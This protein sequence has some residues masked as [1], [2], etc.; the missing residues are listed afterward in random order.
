[1]PDVKQTHL[2][3]GFVFSGRLEGSGGQNVREVAMLAGRPKC[4][5]APR[6]EPRSVRGNMLH[7]GIA[8]FDTLLTFRRATFEGNWAYANSGGALFLYNTLTAIRSSLFSD[9]NWRLRFW[10]STV[11]CGCRCP[12]A[13]KRCRSRLTEPLWQLAQRYRRPPPILGHCRGRAERR[14]RCCGA[15]SGFYSASGTIAPIYGRS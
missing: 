5:R 8:Y 7:T 14:A 9:C 10:S 15:G 13:A 12:A 4:M 6:D 11:S 2:H 1:M 3:P